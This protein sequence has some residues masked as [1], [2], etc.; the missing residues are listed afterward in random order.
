MHNL[1][2]SIVIYKSN[3]DMLRH[4]I[5]SFLHSTKDSHLFLID[6]SP[7]DEARNLIKSE[8]V[9]Y[10]FNNENLGFGSGHNIALQQ[11]INSSKYHVVL[12]PDVFFDENVICDLYN[13]ME[14]NKEIG[15]TMPKVLYPDGRL[16]PLCRL[17]PSPYTLILRRFFNF[18]K[19]LV[20]RQNHAHELHFSGYNKI[21]DVPFLSGCFM[22][23]RIEALRTIGLF[24]E[25]IFL[26]TE[27]LD[28]SRR[29]HKK[30]R[31]VF[32][33]HST[34]YHHHQRGSYHSPRLLLHNIQSAIK[35]FN[36]WGW[37]ND[38]ERELINQRVLLKL[39]NEF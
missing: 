15:L 36:K 22:F 8:R 9:T 2:A 4:T 14:A 19:K 6:N 10:I 37:F 12:N 16:Q 31:T 30:F 11:I 27:D 39:Q 29:I 33:P 35:Y 38:K 13:F 20:E 21:M 3:Q 28:L 17:L 25:R 5:K 1:S 34:I 24:D 26:Y 18:N 7:H 23:L 32:Y